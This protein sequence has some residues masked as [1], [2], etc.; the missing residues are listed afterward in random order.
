MPCIAMSAVGDDRGQQQ[1][2][3]QQQRAEEEAARPVPEFIAEAN[4]KIV[5]SIKG[6]CVYLCIPGQMARPNV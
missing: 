4:K 3:P 6:G 5:S 2:Q 1:Q